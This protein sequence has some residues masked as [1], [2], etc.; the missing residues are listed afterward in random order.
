MKSRTIP[1]IKQLVD[2][3]QISKYR[4]AKLCGVSWATVQHWYKGRF[5]PRA[6]NLE[7]LIKI[8]DECLQ[9]DPI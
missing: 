9:R 8:K 6:E 1:L 4:I 5:E 2:E 3:R 7:Y